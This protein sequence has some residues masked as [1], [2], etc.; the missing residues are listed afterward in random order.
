[1][2]TSALAPDAMV[3]GRPVFDSSAPFER[4]LFRSYRERPDQSETLW[5]GIGDLLYGFRVCPVEL[6]RRVMAGN[7]GMRRFDFDPEVAVRLSWEGV[8]LICLERPGAL[9]PARRGWGSRTSGISATTTGVDAHVLP[10]VCRVPA[11]A[12]AA[13]PAALVRS[14]VRE[15]P[16][17]RQATIQRGC[18]TPPP[19][20]QHSHWRA[21]SRCRDHGC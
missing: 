4:V 14:P 19:H 2:R 9:L 15:T 11:A 16:A 12:A 10:A 21:G 13:R 5:A 20:V 1:M 18:A 8:R 3:L 17:R 6:L 7:R